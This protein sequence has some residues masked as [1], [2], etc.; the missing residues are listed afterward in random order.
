MSKI[1]IQKLAT[2]AQATEAS[3]TGEQEAQE[4]QRSVEEVAEVTNLRPDFLA[5]FD[6]V[7]P[8]FW[9]IP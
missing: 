3:D 5:D 4:A 1:L 6:L 8:D 2:Y 9:V 7:L